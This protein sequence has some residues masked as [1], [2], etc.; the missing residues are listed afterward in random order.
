M[1]SCPGVLHGILLGEGPPGFLDQEIRG[2]GG[3]NKVSVTDILKLNSHNGYVPAM[4]AKSVKLT[5][6]LD[7]M[8]RQAAD[9]KLTGSVLHGLRAFRPG[10][11]AGHSRCPVF[12]NL[13]RL[14]FQRPG[15]QIT[16]T[17]APRRGE[18][19]SLQ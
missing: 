9:P 15:R 5:F 2:R 1:L 14:A 7:P 12:L 8:K 16:Q 17:S 11:L 18:R 10:W 3:R 13:S 4:G 19:P 6:T